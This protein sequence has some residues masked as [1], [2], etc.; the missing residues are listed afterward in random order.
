MKKL[1]TILTIS[2]MSLAG[3]NAAVTAGNLVA[4]YDFNGNTNDGSGNGATGTLTDGAVISADGTGYSGGA[5]DSALDLGSSQNGSDAMQPRSVST[6]D[7]TSSTAN[8][9]IAVSFWQ[10][11]LG[12]GAGG[13]AATSAFGILDGNT[14]R[15]VSAHTPWSDG[16][17]Y[18]DHNGCC[19]QPGQRL[20]A[21]VGTTLLNSWH[22]IV[23]QVDNGNKQIWV[24]GAM[25]GE[26]P[27]GADA[28]PTF[29]GVV[30]VGAQYNDINSFGGRIDEFAIWNVA[31]EESEIQA[32]AG[33]ATTQS[34][35]AIPEPSS[36]LLVLL[37]SLLVAR[38]RR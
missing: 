13:N 26:H 1:T 23:L 10:F 11:D 6:V 37:S 30:N 31:L 9:S 8:N 17:L 29:T 34:I 27:T 12:N 22:H 38:R 7:L 5:G 25:I 20:V 35:I 2:A 33:G 18:F 19:G 28:L 15:G 21:G 16:N 14:G 3:A 32:L 4:F 24:D 36:S